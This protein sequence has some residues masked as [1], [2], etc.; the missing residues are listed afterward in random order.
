MS[1]LLA[2]SP[3]ETLV[4][5]LAGSQLHAIG[6]PEL[7]TGDFA[8]YEELALQLARE[9]RVLSGFRARLVANRATHPLFDM[10]RYTRDFEDGLQTI[11]DDFLAQQSRMSST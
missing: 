7:V 2:I 5:R 4:T 8:A 9:P 1:P 11:W 3:G 6:L 10:A